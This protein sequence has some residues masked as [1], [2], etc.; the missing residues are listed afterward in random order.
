MEAIK[1]QKTRYADFLEPMEEGQVIKFDISA[2]NGIRTVISR[3]LKYSR[4]DLSFTTFI[5]VDE[6]GKRCLYVKR[7]TSEEI[8]QQ[9]Q[10]AVSAG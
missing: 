9:Q 2:R 4:P 3:D 5:K 10:S 1:L 6:K 8:T 7:L